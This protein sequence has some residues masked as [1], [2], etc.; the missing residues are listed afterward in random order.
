MLRIQRVQNS[1]IT[2]IYLYRITVGLSF[3]NSKPRA[4]IT[5]SQITA[6]HINNVHQKLDANSYS[7]S[8]IA[9]S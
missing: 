9:D 2:Q 3:H 1:K 6:V 8:N 7:T 4:Y 5:V